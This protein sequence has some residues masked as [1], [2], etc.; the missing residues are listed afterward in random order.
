MYTCKCS[1]INIL[2]NAKKE[3]QTIILKLNL[4]RFSQSRL[5]MWRA[6]S[7]WTDQ[8]FTLV[9]IHDF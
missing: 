5:S 2:N 9:Q 1:L 3:Q 7:I 8:N 4:E 6:E